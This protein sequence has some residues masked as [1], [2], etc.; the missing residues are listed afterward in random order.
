MLVS[1]FLKLALLIGTLE[2]EL[3]T[4]KYTNQAANPFYQRLGFIM[5]RSCTTPE[6]REMNQYLID[7]N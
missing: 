5:E 4:D 2:V 1:V 3:R 6:G 7:L